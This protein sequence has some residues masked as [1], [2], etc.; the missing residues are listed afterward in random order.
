MCI[1]GISLTR[2][3]RNRFAFIHR[4]NYSVRFRM[5]NLMVSLLASY[6]NTRYAY[7]LMYIYGY[8]TIYITYTYYTY[9]YLSLHY[10]TG[11]KHENII[12][13]IDEWQ[14]HPVISTS[15]ILYS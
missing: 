11:H 14:Q 9:I 1:H 12:G 15:R 13:L 4:G 8:R 3:L 2:P 6:P 10:I 7:D 5:A